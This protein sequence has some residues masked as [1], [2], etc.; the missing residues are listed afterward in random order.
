MFRAAS[1]LRYAVACSMPLCLLLFVAWLGVDTA[2]FYTSFRLRRAGVS[3]E[4]RLELA[5][6]LVF[7]DRAPRM[8]SLLMVPIGISLAFAGHLGVT[9]L[10]RAGKTVFITALAF[11]HADRDHDFQVEMHDFIEQIER[12]AMMVVLVLAASELAWVQVTI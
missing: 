2:V 3:A 11:R 5:H 1:D 4:T 10:S 12:M 8:A 9:G 7:L 6:V